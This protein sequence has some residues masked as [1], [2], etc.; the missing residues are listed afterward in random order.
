MMNCPMK[1]CGKDLSNNVSMNLYNNV[2]M[3]QYKNIKI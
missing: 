3:Y 1:W 2:S